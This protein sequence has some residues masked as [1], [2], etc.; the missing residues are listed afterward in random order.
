MGQCPEYSTENMLAIADA[1]QQ[2][3]ARIRDLLENAQG[4][5]SPSNEENS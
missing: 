1:P 3:D 2:V 5:H 4:I